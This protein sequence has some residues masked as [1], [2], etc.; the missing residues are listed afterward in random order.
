MGVTIVEKG[1]PE[2]E[3]V[4]EAELR[5]PTQSNPETVRRFF[6]KFPDVDV[7]VFCEK[8]LIKLNRIVKECE[9]LFL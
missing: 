6:L 2:T 5:L 1:T 8:Q 7:R 4:K 9:D 3:Q